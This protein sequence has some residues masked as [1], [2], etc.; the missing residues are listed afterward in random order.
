MRTTNK[1]RRLIFSNIVIS[2]IAS[3]MLAT[4]LTTALPAMVKDLNIT[5]ATGQWMT[6]GYTL[7]TGIM[8]PLTAFLITRF[9]T[10]K[11]FLSSQFIFIL[12]LALCAVAPNFFLIM[13]ARLLQAVGCGVISAMSQVIILTIYPLEKRGSAMGWYGLSMGAAPVIAP[14]LAGMIVDIFNWR[15]IFYISIGIMLIALAQAFL[16]FDDLLETA[17]RRFDMFSFVLSIFAFG[18]VTLGIGNLGSAGFLNAQVLCTLAVGGIASALFANRQLRAQTPFLD[19]RVFKNRSFTLS[20]VSSMLLYLVMLGSSVMLP[21]YVQSILGRSATVSGLLVL[22]GAA[23]MA[24][25]SPLAGKIYDKLGMRLLFILGACCM[26]A[27]AV[28]MFLITLQTPLWVAALL[29]VLRNAAI[30]CLMMPLVTWGTSSLAP[31]FTAHATALLNTLRTIAGAIGMSVF[32]GIMTAVSNG[33]EE[34]YGE[35]APLHG[36]N[37]SFLWMGL[38]A[39]ALLLI[40]AVCLKRQDAQAAGTG[41]L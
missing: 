24:V 8:M 10:R 6:S 5:V 16:V 14:T 26:L 25:V 22:P 2:C 37:V 28:G 29:N 30:A 39:L 18:G 3:S 33:S 41:V 27:S 9:S 36:L 20:V 13:A 4:A 38:A 11:L 7:V 15:A 1:K 19:L 12:G 35:L 23:V 21:L 31:R 40:G 34:R 17:K 32:V